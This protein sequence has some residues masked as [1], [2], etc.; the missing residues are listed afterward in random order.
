MEDIK[1]EENKLELS[2]EEKNVEM[3]AKSSHLLR[4][5]YNAQHRRLGDFSEPSLADE[6]ILRPGRREVQTAIQLAST[7][8]GLV[9]RMTRGPGDILISRAPVR[10]ALGLDPDAPVLPPSP[11]EKSVDLTSE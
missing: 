11:A 1:T 8:V 10:R 7:L 6:R 9:G 2:N 5:L 3:L 4:D